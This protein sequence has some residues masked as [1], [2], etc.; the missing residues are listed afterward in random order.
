MDEQAKTGTAKARVR[1]TN[2]R[3]VVAGA[4]SV[5]P[6]TKPQTEGKCG[7]EEGERRRVRS[8]VANT[9]AR[10]AA[11]SAALE[12]ALVPP[13]TSR[14]WTIAKQLMF[15]NTLGETG[16]VDVAV[17]PTGMSL[18]ALYALRR[19]DQAFAAAWADALACHAELAEAI[20]LGNAVNG[21][22]AQHEVEPGKRRVM[23]E[24]LM[25][26]VLRR[27]R[28]RPEGSAEIGSGE[29]GALPP[30]KAG[31]QA[32]LKFEAAMSSLA[33]RIASAQ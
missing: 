32:R 10:R 16:R 7:L 6:T 17:R 19:R 30:G 15:I 23:S 4:A 14:F 9:A 22:D 21:Y 33:D 20:V 29:E 27:R 3:Y 31:E 25:V 5:A 28:A 2:G 13:K 26:E 12:A 8:Y 11:K 18:N 24:R 1:G